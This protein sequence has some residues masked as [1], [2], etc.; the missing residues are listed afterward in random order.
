MLKYFIYCRKSSEDEERQILSIDAQRN[1]LKALAA[2][3]GFPVVDVL[4]ESMSAK[5]TGRPIFN[6]MMKRIEKGEANAVLTWKLDRLA[7]NFDDGGKII[8]MLQRS[9]IAE[10]RSFER[11][12]LPTDN[13]LMMAVEFGMANQYVRD[14]SVN[15]LRGLRE[16]IRR[17]VYPG[18]APLGY[19]NHPELRTIEPHP[20]NFPKMKRILNLFATGKYSLRAIQREMVK[21]GLVGKRSGKPLT[22]QAISWLLANPF[23]YGVFIVK[24]VMHPGI[25]VPMISK[26]T[27][28]EI[29]KARVSVAKP[30]HRRNEDK[31]LLF[32]NFA[33]CGC[34]GYSV[35]G[36]RHTKK[37]GL[38]FL[39]YRCSDKSRTERC[40]ARSYVRAETFATEVK[41]N[42]AL[43][44]LPSELKERF[45]AKVEIW[46]QEGAAAA[47][48]QL[49][50]LRDELK[51][52][53][54]R[55]DRLNTAFADDALEL[56]EFKEMKNPLVAKKI[57]L[58]AKI[59]SIPKRNPN[60]LEPL[61][62]WI[63]EANALENTLSGENLPEMKKF[64]QKRGSN[65][66]L[67]EKKLTVSFVNPWKSMAETKS[68]LGE[69]TGYADAWSRWSGRRDSN[70]RPLE[71]HKE[72]GVFG[73]IRQ[74][75]HSPAQLGTMTLKASMG[76]GLRAIQVRHN[77][78]QGG[79]RFF[80]GGYHRGY[81]GCYEMTNVTWRRSGIERS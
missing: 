67:H 2:A 56:A 25:H 47:E 4:E 22:F 53:L 75:W 7:R 76:K 54:Q 64:L 34:C 17:G 32:L 27:F 68:A 1:E 38:R 41:R 36:E 30:R 21:A 39:Y 63:F 57:E 48:G 80:R 78:A 11:T 13:V 81:H 59:A 16:K 37:S 61:R 70:S 9:I 44:S 65:R 29:Q 52:L 31:G 24:G 55:I 43:V 42:I 69:N 51:A 46:E 8:G 73:T 15:V 10:I 49:A 35:T 66:V 71:P 20:E 60:R 50:H 58:E 72:T 74:G 18:K 5:D 40:Q 28:D 12:Y 14:L 23:Y 79:T 6:A 3:S 33:T 26:A 62:N 45:L 19:F 77:S